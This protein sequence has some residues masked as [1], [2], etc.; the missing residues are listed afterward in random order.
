MAWVLDH[1]YAGVTAA[2]AVMTIVVALCS[3]A[4]VKASIVFVVAGR[5]LGMKCVT[6]LGAMAAGLLAVAALMLA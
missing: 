6:G 3:N 5:S 2:G 4:V 1:V